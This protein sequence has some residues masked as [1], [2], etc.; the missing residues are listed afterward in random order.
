MAGRG[1]PRGFDRD[2]ALEQAMRMFWER[3]Y[4]ATSLS[5]LT[6]A[7]GLRPPSLYAA[8][9]SKEQ[10][11]REAVARYQATTGSVTP[12]ALREHATA[13]A[14]V[15]A[16]L[17]GN[18]CNYTDPDL[19]PGCMVVLAAT[20]CTEDNRGVRDFLAGKRRATVDAVRARLD[21]GV[22]EG[23]LPPGTDTAALAAFCTTVLHG[24]SVQARDGVTRGELLGVV[25]SAMAAWDALVVAAATR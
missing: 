19:P 15:E 24:L 13:R 12:E 23:D 18:A 21:R 20:N 16:A 5:D 17:R 10:L 11:F 4:E 3:G 1:R 6:G 25:D 22:T 2:A 7:M 14:S 8:F 9:G